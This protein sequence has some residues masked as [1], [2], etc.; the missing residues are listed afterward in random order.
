[1]M[2]ADSRSLG[3][4]SEGRRAFQGRWALSA[5]GRTSA[6]SPIDFYY[7]CASASARVG[8]V[9]PTSVRITLVREIWQWHNVEQ[10]L[11]SYIYAKVYE[12]SVVLRPGSRTTGQLGRRPGIN[13]QERQRLT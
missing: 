4:G 1:M 2:L 7:L 9:L 6:R 13:G 10:G 12:S 8:T 11:W 3:S 5:S